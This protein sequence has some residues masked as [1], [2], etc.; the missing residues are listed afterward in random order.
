MPHPPGQSIDVDQALF[1]GDT[2]E[3]DVVLDAQLRQQLA[4]ENLSSI[5]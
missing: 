3:L 5:S 1:A 2:R 4:A